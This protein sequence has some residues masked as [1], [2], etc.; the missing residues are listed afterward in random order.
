[1]IKKVYI[2][3]ISALEIVNSG[4]AKANAAAGNTVNGRIEKNPGQYFC[5]YL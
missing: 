2:I 3:C 5:R 4:G 1:M